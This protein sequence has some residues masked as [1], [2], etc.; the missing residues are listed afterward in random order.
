MHRCN[1]SDNYFVGPVIL[2]NLLITCFMVIN[3]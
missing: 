3:Y 1:I 2:T